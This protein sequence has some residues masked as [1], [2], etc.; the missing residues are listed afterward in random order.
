MT[1]LGAFDQPF[2]KYPILALPHSWTKIRCKRFRNPLHLMWHEAVGLLRGVNGAFSN[3][4][5]IAI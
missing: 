3:S 4:S 2:M 5:D 1:A